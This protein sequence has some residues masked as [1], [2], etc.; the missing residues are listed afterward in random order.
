MGRNLIVWVVEASGVEMKQYVYQKTLLIV[1]II[2]HDRIQEIVTPLIYIIN[3][4]TSNNKNN[5][6]NI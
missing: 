4:Q 1:Q 5:N 3:R 6:Y 2:L